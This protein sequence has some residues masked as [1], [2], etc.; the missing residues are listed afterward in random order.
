MALTPKTFARTAGD[1]EGSLFAWAANPYR[2]QPINSKDI[3]MG[4]T[5]R[6][7]I[8]KKSRH[9]EIERALEQ[10]MPEARLLVLSQ[11]TALFV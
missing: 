11:Q 10:A 1:G 4:E 6:G 8:S 3:Y 5:A 2:W 9:M 7:L